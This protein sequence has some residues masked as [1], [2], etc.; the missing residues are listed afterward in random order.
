MV[1][2]GTNH[3]RN[4]NPGPE[5]NF[6]LLAGLAREAGAA[7]LDLIVFPEYAI[8]GWPYPGEAA[9][10]S[11]AEAVPGDGKWFRRYAALARE[12]GRP[13]LGWMLEKHEG[14]LY[15]A[16]VLFGRGGQFAGKYRKVHANLGEQTWWGWS[17]GVRS[18]PSNTR[19]CA[20]ASAS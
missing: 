8:S 6:N 5:A 20:T 4:G 19:V 1:Q 12:T 3:S 18:P 16:A 14:R 9:F 17:Q 13:I 10:D 2:A 15:N 7:K 11:L